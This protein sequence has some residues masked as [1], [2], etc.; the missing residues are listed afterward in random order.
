MH[1][2]FLLDLLAAG[3]DEKQAGSLLKA[4]HNIKRIVNILFYC[5]NL[6]LL[7]INS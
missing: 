6:S 3:E 2:F 4:N 7:A 1:T 5:K